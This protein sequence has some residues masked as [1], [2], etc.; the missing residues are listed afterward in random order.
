MDETNNK[1]NI[2]EKLFRQ[3]AQHLPVPL[4]YGNR[5]S[6]RNEFVNAQYTKIFGYTL[7]DV[8]TISAW[9]GL[10]YPD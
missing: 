3:F 5:S 1:R 9:W 6:G 8:P 10:A 2:S 7:E 4:V